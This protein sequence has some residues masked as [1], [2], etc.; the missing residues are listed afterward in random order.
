MRS[1]GAPPLVAFGRMSCRHDRAPLRAKEDCPCTKLTLLC[2]SIASTKCKDALVARCFEEFTVTEVRG[3]D[4]HERPTACYRGV[5]Y[6]IPFVPQ[7]R[8]ELN[9]TDPAVDIVVECIPEA[10]RTGG[11]GDGKIF[12]TQLADVIAISLDRPVH[13]AHD[14]PTKRAHRASAVDGPSSSIW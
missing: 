13:A 1:D 14:R 3:H 12:V 5:I 4:S 6:E 2:G 10:A 9:V 11:P 8:I 7:E